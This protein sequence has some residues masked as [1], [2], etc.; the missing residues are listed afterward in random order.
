MLISG[1]HV[2]WTIQVL[3]LQHIL[4]DEFI[5]QDVYMLPEASLRSQLRPD[6]ANSVLHTQSQV[7]HLPQVWQTVVAD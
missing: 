4:Q 6:L 3:K 5:H 1:K 2:C 7:W